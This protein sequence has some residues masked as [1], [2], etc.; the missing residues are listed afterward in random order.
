[1]KLSL[2]LLIIVM[3]VMAAAI[4]GPAFASSSGPVSAAIPATAAAATVDSSVGVGVQAGVLG[5]QAW[6]TSRVDEARDA[7]ER[8]QLEIHL[9]KTPQ[10]DRAPGE[11]VA[12]IKSAGT[13][14]AEKI[15]KMV[16]KKV[17]NMKALE[18]NARLQK[19][20]RP[21]QRL[22][23]AQLNVQIAH[24]LTV[25]DY[26]VLYLSQFKERGAFL[27]AAKK[28]TPEETADL[29]VTYQRHLVGSDQTDISI[30]AVKSTVQLD[31]AGATQP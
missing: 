12:I 18:P 30:P 20:A 25:N 8:I 10:V 21:D 16:E 4:V 13:K 6:K 3:T 1:M 14:G 7:V 31:R 23:Q 9:D 22:R 11:R 15:E 17:E 19:N 26:F 24:E 2:A 28:L 29:M 27:E 5:F